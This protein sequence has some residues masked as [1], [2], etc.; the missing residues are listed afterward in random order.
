M[1][2]LLRNDVP[3]MDLTATPA[4]A[5]PWPAQAAQWVYPTPAQGDFMADIIADIDITRSQADL[6]EYTTFY[7]RYYSVP[8][9]APG[10]P[11]SSLVAV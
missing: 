7:T 1:L 3:F 6:N 11:W 2:D 10:R 8:S 4:L 9:E 5:K